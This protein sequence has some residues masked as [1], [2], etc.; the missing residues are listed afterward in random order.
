MRN[1]G[2]YLIVAPNGY[3]YIGASKNLKKR[4]ATYK[5]CRNIGGRPIEMSMWH[6]SYRNHS[7]T[8]IELCGESDLWELEQFYIEYFRFLGFNLLNVH[9]NPSPPPFART[10]KKSIKRKRL[11][12]WLSKNRLAK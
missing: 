1:C 12:E 11:I 7:I 3:L 4:I 2:V 6:R 9:G 5:N 10:V 8:V